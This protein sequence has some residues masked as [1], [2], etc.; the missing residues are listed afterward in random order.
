[1]ADA[2]MRPLA[3][4]MVRRHFWL[5]CDTPQMLAGCVGRREDPAR[6]Q[7]TMYVAVLYVR[8]QKDPTRDRDD[9][10]QDWRAHA[11]C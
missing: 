9:P 11:A 6:Y 3:G 7:T 5:R 1:M 8:Y 2:Q 4:S 10:T